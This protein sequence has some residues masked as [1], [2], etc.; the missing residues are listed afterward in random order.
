MS[1]SVALSAVIHRTGCIGGQKS[2][3]M[4]SGLT[5]TCAKVLMPQYTDAGSYGRSVHW[6]S[7]APLGTASQPT[8]TSLLGCIQ[9]VVL[10]VAR[11]FKTILRRPLMNPLPYSIV[12]ESPKIV[13]I[14]VPKG[15]LTHSS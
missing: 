3:K 9:S 13:L 2:L 8:R 7:A 4:D 6:G 1:K 5:G 11:I 15:R 14:V 10:S 12:F